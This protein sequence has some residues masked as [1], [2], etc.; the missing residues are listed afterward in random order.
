MQ[1]CGASNNETSYVVSSQIIWT[2]KL[3]N[4]HQGQVVVSE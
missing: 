4:V 2:K 3:N 1:R